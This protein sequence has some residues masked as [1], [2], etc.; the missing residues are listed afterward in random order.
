[1]KWVY[2]NA[3]DYFNIWAKIQGITTQENIEREERRSKADTTEAKD[4]RLKNIDLEDNVI[5]PIDFNYQEDD[6]IWDPTIQSAS[7]NVN[8]KVLQPQQMM[9][10]LPILLAQVKSGNN[11][12]NLLNEIKQIAYSLLRSKHMTKKTYQNILK[13][14]K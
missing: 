4:R 13:F 5:P 6:D 10:R 8:L 9:T 1:M 7:G 2:E 12:K 3:H 11:S 14:A